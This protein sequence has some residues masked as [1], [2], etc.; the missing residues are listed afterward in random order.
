MAKNRPKSCEAGGAIGNNKLSGVIPAAGTTV[1]RT[2]L[3]SSGASH[4]EAKTKENTNEGARNRSSSESER[5][6]SRREEVHPPSRR[7]EVCRQAQ[8]TKYL[9]GTSRRVGC[10]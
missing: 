4:L 2:C 9:C 6:R 7:V 10:V 3:N 8:E 1:S 5:P